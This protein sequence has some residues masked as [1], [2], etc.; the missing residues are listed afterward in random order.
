MSH[1]E[2]VKW[3]VTWTLQEKV[4]WCSICWRGG[5]G[6]SP[7]T[8]IPGFSLNTEASPLAICVSSPHRSCWLHHKWFT[9]ELK[10]ASTEPSCP[11]PAEL[12]TFTPSL[13]WLQLELT[14]SSPCSVG[15]NLCSA[16][17]R[18]YHTIYQ[19]VSN[20]YRYSSNLFKITFLSA[21]DCFRY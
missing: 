14:Q 18:K 9:G 21:L 16:F 7:L 8:G 17:W 1:T 3:K 2:T 19:D 15:E 4:T 13:L 11:K 12:H 10:Q 20:R 5:S 6:Q